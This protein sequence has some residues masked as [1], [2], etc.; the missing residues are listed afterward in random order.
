MNKKDYA[1]KKT[2]ETLKD[3]ALPTEPQKEMMLNRILL[4][5]ECENT[6]ILSRLEQ[7]VRVYP[8]RTAFAA[9]AVQAAALTLIFGTGYTHLFLGVIGG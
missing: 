6:S 3:H 8:W 5:C 1:L 9:S 2:F 4:E 7:V